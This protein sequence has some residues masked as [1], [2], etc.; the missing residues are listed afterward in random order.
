MNPKVSIIIP[1]W[2][3]YEDTAECLSSL[4]KIDYTNYDVYVVD[5]GSKDG[6]ADKIA[7][8]FPYVKLIRNSENLG[9]AEGN[10]IGI[11]EAVRN[12][13]DYILLLNND[14]VVDPKFLSELV[15]VGETDEHIGILGPKIYYYN[16]PKRIWAIGGD[17]DFGVFSKNPPARGMIDKGQFNKTLEFDTLVGAC[18]L[19]KKEV[20]SRIGLLDPDYFHN[21]EEVDYCFRAKRAGYK[22]IYIPSSIIWHKIARSSQGEGSPLNIYYGSRNVLLLAKKHNKFSF[23]LHIKTLFKALYYSCLIVIPKKRERSISAVRGIIDFYLGR[24]GKRFSKQQ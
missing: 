11:R 20:I 10:N 13:P 6:S 7:S 2:N 21:G 22:M 1:N 17:F 15:L 8:Q 16:D 18:M 19:I 9:F 4:K 5:N 3:S 12:N 14:V 23:L 24:Y